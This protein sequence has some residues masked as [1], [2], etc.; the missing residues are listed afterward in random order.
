MELGA[1]GRLVREGIELEL[2]AYC[3]RAV[4][5]ACELAA[6]R[7]GSTVTVITL[8]PPSAEDALREGIAWGLERAVE[9]D[10]VLVSDP[11]F[12]GSDTL[13]TATALAAVVQHLGPFDLI[14]VGRN[15]LDADT[16]Q[17]GPELA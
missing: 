9:I 4:S 5:K 12:A 3:R 16:G 10:G 17:V 8:G 7:E 11:A 2:N 1:D 15:S 6:E 14:L 13:A